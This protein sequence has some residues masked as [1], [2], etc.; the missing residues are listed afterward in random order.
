MLVE[1]F[2]NMFRMQVSMY[3]FTQRE[4]G[5]DRWPCASDVEILQH[6]QWKRT[7]KQMI[8]SSSK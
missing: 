4:T 8:L 3:M 2:F 5:K 1:H 6:L 7:A